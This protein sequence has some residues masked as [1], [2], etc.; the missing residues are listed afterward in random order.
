MTLIDLAEDAVMLSVEHARKA[1]HIAAALRNIL[2]AEEIV[3]A[4]TSVTIRFDPLRLTSADI[5]TQIDQLDLSQIAGTQE[6][7]THHKIPIRY[8]E[9]AGPD[10]KAVADSCG[11]SAN[12]VIEL[13]LGAKYEVTNIGFLP[14]FAYL[15]GLP[16]ALHLPR[17]QT[18]RP[19]LAAGS[20]AIAG[21]NCGIYPLPSPGGWHVIGQTLYPLFD[22]GSDNPFSL[23]PGDKVSFVPA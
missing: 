13:H 19:K 8:G 22:S 21:A 10:L 3:P 12:D 17:R 18:P 9:A 6:N 5:Q 20:V 2:D 14:G 7:P 23:A 15:E 11:L 4:A 1:Q 16:S